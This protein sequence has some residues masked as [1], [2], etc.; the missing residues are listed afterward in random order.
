MFKR[1]QRPSNFELCIFCLALC[2]TVRAMR[3]ALVAIAMC[4]CVLAAR[5]TDAS[6]IQINFTGIVYSVSSTEALFLATFNTSETMSGFYTFESTTPDG[7]PDPDIGSFALTG[8]T[9]SVGSYTAGGTNGQL[10]IV[11]DL[12]SDFYQVAGGFL[13]GPPI[14]TL[15]GTSES[16]IDLVDHTFTALTSGALLLTPPNPSHFDS[17]EWS[18]LFYGENPSDRGYLRGPITSMTLAAPSVSASVPD[19]GA[20]FWL[21]SLGVIAVAGIG[22]RL[23]STQMFRK[24][25]VILGLSV[26]A[27]S[28]QPASANTLTF[29]NIPGGSVQNNAGPMPAYEGFLFL[30]DLFW[31]D[32]VGPNWPYGAHSGEFAIINGNG[33]PGTITAADSSDFT[34]DGL[35]AKRFSQTSGGDTL[36]GTLSGYNNGVAVWSVLTSLNGSYEFYGPQVGAIDELRLG[37]GASFLVDDLSLNEPTAAAVPDA[38]STLALMLIVGLLGVGV[39]HWRPLSA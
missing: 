26:L 12:G 9:I 28:A 4:L 19:A 21:F 34:F 17:N 5:S 39:Q 7:S 18:F 16:Q 36:F 2:A 20:T 27:L 3:Y 25:L 13:S 35:W 22:R 15:T 37:F 32:L 10:S 23:Q 8:Y 11:N 31:I 14:G 29:D 33:G 1:R 30:F 24:T 6:T 38:T